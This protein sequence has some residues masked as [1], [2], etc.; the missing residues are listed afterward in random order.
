MTGALAEVNGYDGAPGRRRAA[1]ARLAR[2]AR[3]APTA[4]AG[5]PAWRSPTTTGPA[6]TSSSRGCATSGSTCASTRSATSSAPRG[7]RRDDRR[8]GDD[9]LA[10]RH[11]R[12][13]AA[14]T[15]A[16]SACSPGSRSSRRS[17]P[18]ASRTRRPLA[19]AFFTDEEGARFAPDML[20]S[21][22][23]VGG[24]A[25][26]EALDIAGRRRRPARRR[27]RPHRL[28]RRRA[29][30]G[31]AR[32]TPSSSCTSSRARC[33]RRGHHD[34]RGHGRA[35]HLVDR[36][37]HHRPVGPRRHDADAAAP[38]RRL[39]AAA[40]SPCFVRDLADEMGGAPGGHRRALRAA[41]E[42]GQRRRRA[43]PS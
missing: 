12:A 31:A 41:P 36:A 43:G 39:L 20:G 33:S 7:R 24:L 25:L 29:V 27:A 3:S 42:P 6:A 2:S 23:Y 40:R 28:R 30:P 9:R 18:P 17:T 15:T 37:D 35:G 16:T 4:T 8:A 5:A 38:R 34:R 19:V 11:G 13:P 14:A 26:E 22:V 21:L 32:R 10:H 1:A